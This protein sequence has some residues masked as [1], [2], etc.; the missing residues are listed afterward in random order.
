M[1]FRPMS[2]SLKDHYHLSDVSYAVY[3]CRHCM[4][5]HLL[6]HEVQ[7]RAYVPGKTPCCAKAF[8]NDCVVLLVLLVLLTAGAQQN[9]LLDHLTSRSSL[10]AADSMSCGAH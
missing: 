7:I 10:I 9:W 3:Q 2:R 4:L 1:Q 8:R 5:G 6:W